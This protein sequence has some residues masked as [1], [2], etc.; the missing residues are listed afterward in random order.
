MPTLAIDDKLFWGLD[1]LEMAAA[2]LRGEPWFQADHWQREGA[3]RP[4]VVR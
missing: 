2:C 3:P 1:G 4:G